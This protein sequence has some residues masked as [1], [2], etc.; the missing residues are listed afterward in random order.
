MTL[1]AIIVPD[2][3]SADALRAKVD[4]AH[5]YPRCER[6]SG[7][8]TFVGGGR[9]V[10]E[11]ARGK[12]ACPCV[13]AA[14]PDPRC[15]FT[16]RAEAPVLTLNDGTFAYP[17]NE[18]K[19]ETLAALTAQERSRIVTVTDDKVV[20]AQAAAVAVADAPADAKAKP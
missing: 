1:R 3:P 9:H 10:G 14:A 17:V 19:P 8:V 5:G 11:D 18:A 6:L 16:T 7:T 15:S 13:D 4:A 2:Q 12:P 20:S